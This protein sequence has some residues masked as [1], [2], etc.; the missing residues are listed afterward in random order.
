MT[1]L[2]DEENYLSRLMALEWGTP[3]YNAVL[4]EQAHRDAQARDP[5]QRALQVHQRALPKLIPNYERAR[6]ALV[7]CH[8]TDE[9]KNIR[10]A[11]EALRA[12][13]RIVHDHEA[14]MLWA[15]VKLRAFRR[16]GEL[17]RELEVSSHGPGRGHK[18]PATSGKA[19][20]LKATGISP[21]AAYRAERIAA[22]PQERFDAYLA[23]CR[24]ENR[25]VTAR[26]VMVTVSK[27]ERMRDGMATQAWS[28]ALENLLGCEATAGKPSPRLRLYHQEQKVLRSE[29]DR[30]MHV[31]ILLADL[32]H[33][34][35]SPDPLFLSKKWLL[36]LQRI[37][38]NDKLD[39]VLQRLSELPPAQQAKYLKRLMKGESELFLAVDWIDVSREEHEAEQ[40]QSTPHRE[41]PR[42]RQRI[43]RAE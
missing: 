30:F 43:N 19:L 15:E 37:L 40:A 2:D 35:W 34:G 16:L 11:A 39:A 36:L 17:S 25:A 8:R 23:Q 18:R 31:L 3:E 33:T 22:I 13:A 38:E 1:I 5:Y 32:N 26:E 24:A 4:Q 41:R 7:A 27:G 21:S 29:V 20:T 42:K 14:E 28:S 9:A 6:L 12:Y 10:D